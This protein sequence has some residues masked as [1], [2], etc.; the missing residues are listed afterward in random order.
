MAS[1]GT[2][3]KRD[4]RLA[5]AQAARAIRSA[6]RRGADRIGA[7]PLVLAVSGGADSAAMAIAFATIPSGKRPA[8]VLAHFSHGLRPTADKRETRLVARL[9]ESLGLDVKLGSASVGPSEAAAREA[10]YGFLAK[11]SAELGAC[12]VGT[13]HTLDD[14]AETALLRLV[15]GAGL[16]GGGGIREWSS[17]EI[18]S[19]QVQLLRPLLVL[20]REQTEAVCREADYRPAADGSNRS[21]RFARN[22]VR[23]RVLPELA[24]INPAARAALARFA[25]NAREDDEALEALARDAVAGSERRS[26]ERVVWGRTKLAQLPMALLVRVL[27]TAWRHV[28]GDAAALSRA[29][30]DAMGRLIRRSDGGEITLGQG[31]RFAIDQRWC[32]IERATTYLATPFDAELRVPGETQAGPWHVRAAAQRPTARGAGDAWEM[33]MDADRVGERLCVRTRRPGERFHPAGMPG[34]VRLQDLLVNAKVPRA[35]RDELPLVV[36][37]EGIAW[38]PGVRVAEWAKVIEATRTAV[39]VSVQRRES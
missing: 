2:K 31:W 24:R 20:T 6:L 16:R 39:V 10:R 9:A 34:P 19:H 28:A 3:R 7:G 13:A 15:R 38:V 14:Q 29:K 11:V 23:S 37:T 5:T 33:A 12:A 22:R 27:Q 26:T 25:D 32:W 8:L 35:E 1:A 21:L 36:G 4:G 17:R 30:L 18:G